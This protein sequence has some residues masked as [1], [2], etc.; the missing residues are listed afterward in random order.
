[1]SLG[2]ENARSTNILLGILGIIFSSFCFAVMG[3]FVHLAGDLPFM[4]KAFFRNL[5]SF[6]I[7]IPML[8]KDR[9]KI[10]IPKGTL[11]FLFLR[12]AVGSIGIFGNFYAIDRIPIADAAILNRMSSFFAIIFSLI[13]LGEKIKFIPFLATLGAFFGAMFVIKPSSNFI[14]SFPAF[15]GFLGGMGAGFA[16]ACVRKLGTMK[17]NGSVV[18]A[19]FSAFSCLLCVPFIIAHHVP[20]TFVQVL[21]LLGTGLAGCGGQF[22]MTFGYYHAP[23][24]DISIFDYSQIIFSAALGYFLFRQIPDLLSWIGYAI[25]IS[26]ATIVF[27]YNKKIG[28]FEKGHL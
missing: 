7:T 17:I 4:Q 8:A 2:L 26:M 28:E 12:A 3:A 25:I 27:L 21:V 10:S 23:A 20:M 13:L 14:T 19:F 16:F 9:E 24:R 11:K 15:V 1:M 6:F 18:I 5:I 22:G